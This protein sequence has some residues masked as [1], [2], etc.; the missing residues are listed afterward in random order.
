M[1]STGAS[2]GPELARKS[3]SVVCPADVGVYGSH[4][5]PW[6]PRSECT[7]KGL[8]VGLMSLLASRTRERWGWFKEEQG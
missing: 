8:E 2:K 5:S 1:T 4:A 6:L 7:A 3:G